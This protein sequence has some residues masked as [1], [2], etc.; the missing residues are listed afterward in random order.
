MLHENKTFPKNLSFQESNLL[1]IEQIYIKS[2]MRLMILKK[3]YK[4]ELQNLK[5]T[6]NNIRG[7]EEY[8]RS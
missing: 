7:S 3:Y 2:T 6:K 4:N 1:N 8:S 5:P